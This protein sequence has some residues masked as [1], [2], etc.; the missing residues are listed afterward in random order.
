MNSRILASSSRF[1]QRAG[2]GSFGYAE[3]APPYRSWLAAAHHIGE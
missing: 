2:S 1:G 3:R